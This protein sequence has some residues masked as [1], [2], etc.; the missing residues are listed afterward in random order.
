M[1]ISVIIPVYNEAK[2]LPVVL[3][4]VQKNKPAEIIIVDDGSTDGTREFLDRYKASNVKVFKHEH[5]FGKGAALRT[6][7]KAATQDVVLIQDADL[8]YD[9]SEYER[10]IAPI[11]QGYADVV[12]GSRFVGSDPHRVLFFWHYIGNRFL[13]FLCNVVANLNLTDMETGFK[14]FKKEAIHSIF[15]KEKQFGIEPEITIKLANKGWRF[16]EVG[17][18]Y[19]GRDY[20]EGKKIRWTDGFKAIFVILKYG[21]FLPN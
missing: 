2:T 14:A 16:Y 18:S 20:K 13:T 21:L 8:E 4:R 5:N 15:L 11:T 3:E 17:I 10:L 6:G 12:Y 9:P 7:I 19:Y 1:K